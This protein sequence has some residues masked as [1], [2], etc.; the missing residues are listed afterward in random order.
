MVKW[1]EVRAR[2]EPGE[3]D[4][5]AALLARFGQ[6]GSA[7][8][9]GEEGVFVQA[10][11]PVDRSLPRKKRQLQVALGHL[12]LISSLKLEERVIEEDWAEAYKEFFKPVAIG[13]LVV[14]PPWHSYQAS[15]G[16]L[17]LELEPGLAFGTGHHP[18]TQMCLRLLEKHLRPGME[19]LDLGTGSGILALAAA[20]LGAR[21][22][23][24]LDIDPQAVKAARANVRRNGPSRLIQVRLGTLDGKQGSFDLVVANLTARSLVGLASPLLAALKSPGLLIAGGIMLDRL[25][26][27]RNSLGVGAREVE[28]ASQGDWR[29]LV[30][31]R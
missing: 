2:V 16:E 14:K 4:D 24:A 3:A 17:V 26:E 23:L 25:E 29:T 27:V 12:S 11:L 18:T 15:P 10:Y 28:A 8:V 9:E 13:R 22:V 6:G 31:A 21:K 20:L 1:L 5:V 19:V 7:I 30:L